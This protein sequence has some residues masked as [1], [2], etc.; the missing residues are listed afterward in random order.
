MDLVSGAI[1]LVVSTEAPKARSGET[2]SSANRRRME[3][4]RSLHFASLRS[5]PVETTE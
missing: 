4:K 3:E 1:Y 5:A 2:L